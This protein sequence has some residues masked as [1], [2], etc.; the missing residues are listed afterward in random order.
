[1]FPGTTLA[2]NEQ[3]MV[4]HCNRHCPVFFKRRHLGQRNVEHFTLPSQ[5]S[6]LIT[7]NRSRNEFHSWS[8]LRND[9]MRF[10]VLGFKSDIRIE[11]Q[12]P[13]DASAFIS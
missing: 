1:M 9:I 10:S 4:V 3:T 5:H 2:R 11:L 7:G 8:L 6:L 12:A 13:V